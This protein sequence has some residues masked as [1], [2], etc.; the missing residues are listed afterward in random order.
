[1]EITFHAFNDFFVFIGWLFANLKVIFTG[2]LSPVNYIFNVLRYFWSS[3]FLTPPNPDLTFVF[4]QDVLNVFDA[5]PHWS[6][7]VLVIGAV[8]LVVGGIAILKLF[9]HT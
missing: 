2:L 8:V 3:A 4:S 1:M 5:I 7:F 6:S 9:L